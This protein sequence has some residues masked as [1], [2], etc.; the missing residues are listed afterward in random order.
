MYISGRK[1]RISR[2]RTK[3]PLALVMIL[4]LLPVQAFA[5]D[6]ANPFRDVKQGDWRYEAVQYVWVNGLFNGTSHTTFSPNDTVKRGMFVTVLGRLAG[7]DTFQ[8]QGPS[9]FTDVPEDACFAPYVAWAATVCWRLDRTV[10][11]WYKEPGVASERVKLDPATGLPYSRQ[12]PA[13]P[14]ET[15]P[16]SGGNGSGSSGGSTSGGGSPGGNIPGGDSPGG[17]ASG[18]SGFNRLSVSFYDASRLIERISGQRGQPLRKVPSAEKASKAGAVLTGWY[19]DPAFTEP[20]YADDPIQ[21]SQNV[22]AKYEELGSQ[23]EVL[24]PSSFA[25]MDQRPD[26]SSRIRRVSGSAA[27]MDAAR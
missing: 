15:R 22:Y 24:T 17:N 13:G 2:K 12:Q 1:F 21:G 4:T 5:V 10:E 25:Q 23:E 26:L 19:A 16:A 6:P 3:L 7:V 14:T 27:P 9:A 18:G 20:F 11:T 8:Y